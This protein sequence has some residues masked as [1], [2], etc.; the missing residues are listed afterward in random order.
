MSSVYQPFQR[1]C[2]WLAFL[3]YDSTG[4][5]EK[6]LHYNVGAMAGKRYLQRH[7]LMGF[8]L[9]SQHRG[10][11]DRRPDW[12]VSHLPADSKVGW[13]WPTCFVLSRARGA[14]ISNRG[15]D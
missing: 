9:Y 6:R 10:W 2:P 11:L 14:T 8:R 13:S 5:W 7:A 4:Q 12:H 15:R 3:V 1:G